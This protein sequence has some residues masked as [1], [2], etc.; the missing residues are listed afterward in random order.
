VRAGPGAV[1]RPAEPETRGACSQRHDS[2]GRASG[3]TNDKAC[4]LRP[5][6][7]R[8]RP[9]EEQVSRRAHCARAPEGKFT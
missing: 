2:R 6:R 8:A 7:E 4:S 1:S 5:D 9:A 3:P